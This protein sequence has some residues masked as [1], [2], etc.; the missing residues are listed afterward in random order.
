MLLCNFHSK[1]HGDSSELSFAHLVEQGWSTDGEVFD[2]AN[3]FETGVNDFRNLICNRQV[4][5]AIQMT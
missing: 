5:K 3:N 4:L 2:S 1:M